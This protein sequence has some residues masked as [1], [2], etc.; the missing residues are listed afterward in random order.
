MTS[1]SSFD[2]IEQ[3]LTFPFFASCT[4]LYAC[5][6]LLA[7][8]KVSSRSKKP[9]TRNMIIAVNQVVCSTRQRMQTAKKFFVHHQEMMYTKL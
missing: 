4:N 3:F 2:Y 8:N 5:E 1:K 7:Q 6:S 9:S